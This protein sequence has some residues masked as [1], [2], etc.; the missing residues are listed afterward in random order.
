MSK[1][2]STI[3]INTKSGNDIAL[4]SNHLFNISIVEVFKPLDKFNK[5]LCYQDLKFEDLKRYF[6]D[7]SIYLRSPEMHAITVLNYRL[8]T[9]Y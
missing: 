4:G 1:I 8:N 2:L 7:F 3:M 9:L 6:P 5:N